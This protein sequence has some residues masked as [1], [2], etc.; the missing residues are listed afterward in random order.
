VNP[1][2]P[3]YQLP[4]AQERPATP[5]RF[6]RDAMGVSDIDGARPPPPASERVTAARTTPLDVSDID[7]ACPSTVAERDK[8]APRDI[9]SSKTVDAPA[10]QRHFR[11][12]RVTDPQR[13]RHVM[14]GRVIEDDDPGGRPRRHVGTAPPRE[15]A[16]LTTRDIEGATPGW[17]PPHS[18]AAA[19]PSA[20][21]RQFRDVTSVADVAGAQASTMRRGL[22]TER[23]TDPNDRIYAPLD[24]RPPM[25]RRDTTAGGEDGA[26]LN[27]T[28]LSKASVSGGVPTGQASLRSTRA[29]EPSAAH[30]VRVTAANA[31]V[32]AAEAEADSLRQRVAELE[33]RA[34]ARAEAF[35][36]THGGALPR[37]AGA[38]ETK[39][40]GAGG[41]PRSVASG[42][43]ARLSRG[44]RTPGSRGPGSARGSRGGAPPSPEEAMGAGAPVPPLGG[45]ESGRGAPGPESALS[46]ALGSA[47]S[48]ARRPGAPAGAT[49]ASMNQY[50]GMSPPPSRGLPARGS[51][52]GSA[53]SGFA[54]PADAS[55][56]QT[57]QSSARRSAS[58]KPTAA[59]RSALGSAGH[60]AVRSRRAPSSTPRIESTMV[61]AGATQRG[62]AAADHAAITSLP[63]Y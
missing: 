53:R 8:P 33:A 10:V 16:S 9:L 24:G 52:P 26:P 17:R 29:A 19:I 42:G 63:D 55:E 46:S 54:G 61:Y 18:G 44:G 14:H 5:P 47:L 36:V 39:A 20:R 1:L 50:S 48:S 25:P 23:V 3:Q 40:P 12:S 13:P 35:R 60:D 11:S 56:P 7:G 59:P 22:V 28:W 38:E 57:R 4:T 31:R 62:Q 21:R 27:A 49:S 51:A 45:M 34:H 58:T 30:V 15:A 41:R 2:E 43:S 6:V 37:E 32:A